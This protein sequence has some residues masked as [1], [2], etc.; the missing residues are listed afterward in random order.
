MQYIVWS[1]RCNKGF[2]LL[3]W[4]KKYFFLNR[5][6][7]FTSQLEVQWAYSGHLVHLQWGTVHLYMHCMPSTVGTNFKCV[8]LYS[9][10]T[11]R[12]TTHCTPT[13]LRAG[14]GRPHHKVEVKYM[15]GPYTLP[16]LSSLELEFQVEYQTKLESP[17]WIQIRI[18]I[19]SWIVHPLGECTTPFKQL[20]YTVR[21]PWFSSKMR[22]TS[23]YIA[24]D[25]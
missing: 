1:T 9:G 10:S 12:T 18:G 24:V 13:A 2:L 19:L 7:F 14:I 20:P 21:T 5:H 3:H 25:N 4:K 11:V 17:S 6:N 8:V 15:D 23:V 22:I 16:N